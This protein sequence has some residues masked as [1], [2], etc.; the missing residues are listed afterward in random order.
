MR[1]DPFA[2]CQLSL[3]R[4]HRLILSSQVTKNQ[5]KNSL[6]SKKIASKKGK[7]DSKFGRWMIH[8]DGGILHR[9]QTSATAVHNM[10]RC[11]NNDQ[12]SDNNN[13]VQKNSMQQK[14]Q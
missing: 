12:G 13:K 14:R 7:K 9:N 1:T 3:T 8:T 4:R 10:M 5:H 2:H 11:M 6:C